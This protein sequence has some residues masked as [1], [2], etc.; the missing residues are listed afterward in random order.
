MASPE[1]IP[2]CPAPWTLKATA[3]SFMF[4]QSESEAGK[5]PSSFL[6]SPL[7]AGSNFAKQKSLGGLASVQLIRYS[8][9]PVGPYDELLFIP[10]KFATG[11]NAPQKT[12][13]KVSRIYVSQKHTCYNGRKSKLLA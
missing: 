13:L 5:I 12:G 6:Y 9:T 7:E 8:D 11:E 3:Y 10:G 1:S 4:Y 2:D